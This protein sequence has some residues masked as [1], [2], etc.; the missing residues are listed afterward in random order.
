MKKINILTVVIMAVGIAVF[1]ISCGSSS[2]SGGGGG[3][4]NVS[5]S[6]NSLPNAN[7][8]VS[9][10]GGAASQTLGAASKTPSSPNP[11]T[12]ASP[13]G[14]LGALSYLVSNPNK[15]VI[16]PQS[17]K[18]PVLQALSNLKLLQV[19]SGACPGGGTINIVP[20]STS[21]T[22]VITFNNCV[23]GPTT[24]NGSITI[25]ANSSSSTSVN[26][27][28]TYSAFTFSETISGGSFAATFNGSLAFA[29]TG[30]TVNSTNITFTEN[31]SITISGSAANWTFP[32]FTCN[33]AITGTFSGW[34]SVDDSF[35]GSPSTVAVSGTDGREENGSGT[36]SSGG[37]F[38]Y[39][40]GSYGVYSFTMAITGN[41]QSP[42]TLTLN[43]SGTFGANVTGT[44]SGTSSCSALAPTSTSYYGKYSVTLDKITFDSSCAYAPSGGTLTITA[45]NTWVFDFTAGPGCGCAVVKE[46]NVTVPQSPMCGLY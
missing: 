34:A 44:V 41:P 38:A 23:E 11:S 12:L 20:G 39:K 25:S 10:V 17:M 29:G 33:E 16:K 45:D 7:L 9:N 21:G 42:T 43:G 30:L 5:G 15:L 4:G 32:D 14:A 31:G 19:Y 13:G 36:S 28:I 35:S 18:G 46:N 22:E 1:S 8:T 27:T 37:S 3:G 40:V 2:S 6:L 26:A 24:L